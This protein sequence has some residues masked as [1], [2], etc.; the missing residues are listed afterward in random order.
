MRYIFRKEI[1]AMEGG[2][3]GS[4]ISSKYIITRWLL[5]VNY[6]PSL[7]NLILAL[8]ILGS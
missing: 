2:G 8:N 4:W 6:P 1:E 3:V 5:R 7:L